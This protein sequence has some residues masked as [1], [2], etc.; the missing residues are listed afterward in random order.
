MM[1]CILSTRWPFRERNSSLGG[2]DEPQ[3]QHSEAN[4]QGSGRNVAE[5][6]YPHDHSDQCGFVKRVRFLAEIVGFR[7]EA[8]VGE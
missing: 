7:D 6:C 3:D 4:T 2:H 8:G 5:D 1:E